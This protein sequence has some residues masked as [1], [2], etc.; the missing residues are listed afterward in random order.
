KQPGYVLRQDVQHLARCIA[1]RHSLCVSGKNREVVIPTRG[2]FT[3]LHLLDFEG[4]F[5][6]LGAIG[7][8]EGGPLPASLCASLSDSC[9]EMLVHALGNPKLSIF[10]PTIG[11]FTE[12]DLILAE[13]LAMGRGG[14]LL[15]WGTVA[16]V[17]VEHDESGPVLGLPEDLQCMLDSLGIVGV[18]D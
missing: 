18:A 8:K 12:A 10:R 16:D 9:G 1:S 4:E 2:Q 7:L 3:L 13:W 17:A 11:S 15:M 14:V 5:R 6:E